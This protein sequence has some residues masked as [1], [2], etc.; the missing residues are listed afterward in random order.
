MS[1]ED[2]YLLKSE[3]SY[4][5]YIEL[6]IPQILK[7]REL[8]TQIDQQIT[9]EKYHSNFTNIHEELYYQCLNIE[10]WYK[11]EWCKRNLSISNKRNKY[12]LAHKLKH[13]AGFLCYWHKEIQKP[14]REQEFTD[15]NPEVNYEFHIGLVE[16]FIPDIELLYDFLKLDLE[17]WLIFMKKKLDGNK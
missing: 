8:F 1:K 12:D 9:D 7:I 10:D 14:L 13:T 17:H 5:K 15:G 2:L 6:I 3:E 4:K 11:F 16:E